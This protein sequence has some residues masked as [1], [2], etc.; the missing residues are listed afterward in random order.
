MRAQ[1]TAYLHPFRIDVFTCDGCVGVRFRQRDV[2]ALRDLWHLALDGQD[3]LPLC[4]SLF[5][6]GL[7]LLM[8]SDQALTE[9]EK[10][11]VTTSILSIF[12]NLYC[13]VSHFFETSI[14]HIHFS[15]DLDLLNV[16]DDKHVLQVLHCWLH[17]VVKWC[18]PLRI[19]QVKLIYSL[20][21]LLFPLLERKQWRLFIHLSDLHTMTESQKKQYRQGL[22]A[23]LGK[24]SQ[25]VPLIT[26]PRTA[27]IDFD[28]VIIFKLTGTQENSPYSD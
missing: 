3:G 9:E 25:N 15:T 7:E 19:L 20:Q 6:G 22:V 10:S 4:I 26:D 14:G 16:V 13:H 23:A 18:C 1:A 24:G 28:R 2:V 17:P 8:G 11:R 5:Q 27:I 12:Y 21:L